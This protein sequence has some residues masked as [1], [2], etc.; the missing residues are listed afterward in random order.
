MRLGA[1]TAVLLVGLLLAAG[2]PVTPETGQ[3][4]PQHT[5]AEPVQLAGADP[6]DA[7]D[8]L[9]PTEPGIVVHEV[10]VTSRQAPDGP[11][12]VYHAVVE[13]TA[14]REQLGRLDVQVLG[15]GRPVA[16]VTNEPTPL[17]PGGPGLLT[18]IWSPANPGTYVLEADVALAGQNAELPERQVTVEDRSTSRSPA[19]RGLGA[20][21]APGTVLWTLAFAWVGIRWV[22]RTDGSDGNT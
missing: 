10:M 14:D 8:E 6:A 3:G 5:G 4:D 11:I 18:A 16:T 21:I 2:S 12:V 15:Q 22:Q 9:L 13:N 17:A 7:T 20:L 19:D 1:P